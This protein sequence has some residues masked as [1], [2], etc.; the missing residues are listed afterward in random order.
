MNDFGTNIHYID[1]R[2]LED[3]KKV[4]KNFLVISFLKKGNSQYIK[5]TKILTKK[6]YTYQ[7]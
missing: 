6:I 4:I 5:K 1:L 2:F 3:F 7:S